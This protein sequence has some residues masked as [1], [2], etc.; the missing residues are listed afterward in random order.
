MSDKYS[1]DELIENHANKDQYDPMH[2]LDSNL[3]DEL[4]H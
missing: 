1:D 3:K 4:M 2:V